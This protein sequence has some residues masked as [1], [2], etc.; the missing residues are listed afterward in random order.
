MLL[1]SVTTHLSA[2]TPSWIRNLQGSSYSS[3]HQFSHLI[4][5]FKLETAALASTDKDIMMVT[6]GVPETYTGNLTDFRCLHKLIKRLYSP[7][8]SQC[9]DFPDQRSLTEV[10]SHLSDDMVIEVV[11]ARHLGSLHWVEFVNF[12]RGIVTAV[13]KVHKKAVQSW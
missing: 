9:L 10:R 12:C 7:W 13:R 4:L 6:D 2:P 8:W 1:S 3:I 5:A 11:S